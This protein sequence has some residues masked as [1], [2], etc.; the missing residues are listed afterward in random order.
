M[1]SYTPYGSYQSPVSTKS[2]N[3]IQVQKHYNIRNKKSG[4]IILNPHE[5]C[6]K[7]NTFISI[8]GN[9]TYKTF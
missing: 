6:L 2:N 3:K 8:T 9:F 1:T 5:I 4:K 7:N